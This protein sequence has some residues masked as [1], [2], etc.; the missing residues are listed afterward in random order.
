M[1]TASA[2]AVA[3]EPSFRPSIAAGSGRAVWLRSPRW[4]VALSWAKA[5]DAVRASSPTST[6]SFIVRLRVFFL[7]N[8]CL[9]AKVIGQGD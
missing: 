1:A 7:D 6:N 2:V 3:G 8:V 5:M 9:L 4:A